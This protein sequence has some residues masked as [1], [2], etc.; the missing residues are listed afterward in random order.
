MLNFSNKWLKTTN[1]QLSQKSF[2][3]CL[4]KLT[5]IARFIHRN[6]LLFYFLTNKKI[7]EKNF[8]RRKKLDNIVIF[9]IFRNC[10]KKGVKGDAIYFA[11]SPKC[12]WRGFSRR[13]RW[14]KDKKS[15]KIKKSKKDLKKKKIRQVFFVI[16]RKSIRGCWKFI[17]QMYDGVDFFFQLSVEGWVFMSADFWILESNDNIITF[18]TSY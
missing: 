3:T 15:K 17:L 12:L 18:L 10:P 9:S 2:K 8:K 11:N 5:I 6:N 4:R 7:E 16:F 13:D 14:K 1:S